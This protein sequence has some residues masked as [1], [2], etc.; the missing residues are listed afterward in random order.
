MRRRANAEAE[1]K[2]TERRQDD[3]AE[4]TIEDVQAATAEQK[5]KRA[6]DN[7]ETQ[8][9]ERKAKQRKDGTDKAREG[10]T[11]LQAK[12]KEGAKPSEKATVPAKEGQATQNRNVSALL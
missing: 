11:D 1:P 5:Q 2:A 4:M 9:A 3:G 8:E 12:E 10:Q 7:A 6:V